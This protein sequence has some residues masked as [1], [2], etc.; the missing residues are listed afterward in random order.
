[1]PQAIRQGYAVVVTVNDNNDVHAF[2]LAAA[3]APLFLE[4]KNDERSRIKETAVDAEALLPDGPYDL[5]R[6]NEDARFVKDLANAFARDPRLPKMLNAK[7]VLD[8]VL[9]GV[10]R[11]LFVA[12]LARPDGSGRTWWHTPVDAEAHNDPTLEVVLPQ[13]AVLSPLSV[14]LLAPG[15]LPEL[16]QNERL[17]LAQ[18]KRYFSGKHT[19]TVARDGWD[20]QH[21]IPRCDE[22]TLQAA[23]EGAVKAGTIWLV[24]G[25]TSCWKEDVPFAALDDKSELLPPP[26]MIAPQELTRDA[27]PGA[28]E[29]STTN[30]AAVVRALSQH[31][32]IAVPWGLVRD[33]LGEAVRSRWLETVQ[34]DG[35][36]AD[37]ERAG[38]WRLRL[39]ADGKQPAAPRGSV[40]V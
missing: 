1:M 11:G 13:Q 4:I 26:A 34:G 30:G 17:T 35:A 40:S 24:N 37:F 19:V 28:W 3:A 16:W 10:E 20:E 9:Q 7:V 18:A 14:E 27:L 8:T 29:N 33:S 36:V 32:G 22:E 39:P 15:A 6:N 38:A 2:R 31:R 23:L 25:P 5:W 12:R 21:A